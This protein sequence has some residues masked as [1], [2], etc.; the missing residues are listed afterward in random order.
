MDM[1]QKLGAVLL[2]G[3]DLGHNVAWADAYLRTKW[4]PYQ[5]NR[6]ATAHQHHRQDRQT[7][8]DRTIVR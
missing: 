2:R 6:L 4:H 8:Q 7:G 1:G 3:G 5:S